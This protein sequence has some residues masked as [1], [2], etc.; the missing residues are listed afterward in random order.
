MMIS[1]NDSGNTKKENE[2]NNVEKI[3]DYGKC[4][5]CSDKASGIHY[6]VTSCE[7]CKASIF[8]IIL[9]IGLIHNL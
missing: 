3:I 2:N 5:I 7:A 1:N 8:E 6:S 9:K 4:E